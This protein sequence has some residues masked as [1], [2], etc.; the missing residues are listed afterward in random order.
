MLSSTLLSVKELYWQKEIYKSWEK[1]TMQ[2]NKHKRKK[3]P[4]WKWRA[5]FKTEAD[6]CRIQI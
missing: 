4:S 3:H 1:A 2:T 6:I 5:S